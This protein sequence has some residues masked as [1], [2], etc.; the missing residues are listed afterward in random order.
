MRKIILP[1]DIVELET[2]NYHLMITSKFKDGTLK[3][4]VIDTGASKSV[5]DSSLTGYF[6]EIETNSDED[7]HSAG[8]GIDT[9]ETK[10][11]EIKS[12]KFE[13]FKVKKFRVALINLEHINELYSK[14]SS[15]K[16]CGLL[17]SDFLHKNKAIINY[18]SGELILSNKN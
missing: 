1:I 15:E 10:V 16:I 8:I 18:A 17:G 14:Y 2:D 4:W 5:F 7:M 11:G 3:K 13:K 6:K 12:L 9:V